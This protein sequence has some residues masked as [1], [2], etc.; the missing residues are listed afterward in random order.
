MQKKV[1]IGVQLLTG[2]LLVI[3]G[4]NKLRGVLSVGSVNP[5]MDAFLTALSATGYLMELV[6]I[7]EI[8]AGVAFLLNKYTALMAVV[9]MPVLLNALLAHLFLNPAGAG[10]PLVLMLFT[11]GVMYHH[12]EQYTRIL[13][14]D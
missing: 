6:A 4:V 5:A 10:G 8:L 11:V 2:L 14:P 1:F 3:V 9:L 7:V 12:R 13:Q